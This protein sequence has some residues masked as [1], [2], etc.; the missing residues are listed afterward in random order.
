M[1]IDANGIAV[2]IGAVA[3]AVPL[4]GGFVLQ[5]LTYRKQGQ[6]EKQQHQN[7]V[8][9]QRREGKLDAVATRVNGVTEQAIQLAVRAGTAEGKA[10]LVPVAVKVAGE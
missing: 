10:L 2:V 7:A 3:A 1:S 5:C 4:I 8:D 9:G 6:L